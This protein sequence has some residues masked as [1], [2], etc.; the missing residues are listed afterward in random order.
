MCADLLI[1]EENSGK[2]G[3]EIERSVGGI[4]GAKDEGVGELGR[5]EVGGEES[6]VVDIGC[7]FFFCHCK[8]SS[9]GWC[10][11]IE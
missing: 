2:G 4:I 7:F 9:G 1:V 3:G 11:D 6:L 10:L 8:R 5:G